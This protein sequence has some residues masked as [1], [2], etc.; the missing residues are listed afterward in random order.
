MSIRLCVIRLAV[1]WIVF[2]AWTAVLPAA[3]TPAWHDVAPGVLRSDGYPCAYALTDGT[4]ALLIG[5]PRGARLEALKQHGVERCELVLLTHHHRDSCARAADWLSAGIAV[6]APRKAETLLAPEGVRSYWKTS[7]PVETPGRFPPL[8]ER[9][10]G[11]WFYLVVPEG[12]AGIRYDLDDGQTISWHE[13]KIEVLAT[14]GHSP[15]HMAFLARRASDG[16]IVAFCGDAL[17]RPGKIWSPYTTDWHH[18]NDD[19]PRAAAGSLR[20]LAARRPTILCPEHGP[21]IS[22]Q[23]IEA[24]ETTAEALA[25]AALLK[26]YERYTKIMVGQPPRYPFLATDQVGTANPQGN[27]QPWTKLS[28][29]LFLTGNTYALASKD[30]PVL[31]VDPYSQNL[32]QRVDELRRDH[33]FGPVEVLTISHAHN[34]HYTG[35]FALPHRERYQVW[36]L[37]RIADVVSAPKRFRAP[38]VDARLVKVDRRLKD[39]DTVMWHEYQLK[40]RHQPGQTVF[41]MGLEVDVDGKKCLFSGDNFYHADQYSGSGGWSGLNR[42]LPNGYAHSLKAVIDRPPDWILAEHGGAFAYDREDFR[43]RLRWAQESASVADALSPEGDQAYDWDPHRIRIEPQIVAAIPGRS[44]R[45]ALVTTNPTAKDRSY[46]IQLSRPGVIQGHELTM[47]VAAHTERRTELELSIDSR[48]TKGTWIVPAT[49]WEGANEDGS[50]T[51]AVLE[52]E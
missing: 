50:D 20:A 35:I 18:V 6:R 10:W 3:D 24:L 42:G 23:V 33:G 34:D 45:V 9:F 43:R 28:D 5:A 36:A 52:V 2:V 39:G 17:C 30:G 19:G 13:W 41:A 32:V 31:L 40:I 16:P 15:D 44:V 29:H 37:D 4:A 12:L 25:R 27:P 11:R 51:F 49:V 38:Y 26:S 8:T 46:R 7:M 14:P 22:K 47:T 21:P 1:G 48:L